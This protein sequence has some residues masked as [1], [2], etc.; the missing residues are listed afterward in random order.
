M[1]KAIMKFKR[2][3]GVTHK[4]TLP[5]AQYVVGST[6]GFTAKPAADNDATDAK[7][8]IEKLFDDTNVDLVVDPLSATYNLP[9]T[10]SDTSDI[11][12]DADVTKMEYVG[13]FQYI[14]PGKEPKSFPGDNNYISV[15]VYSDIRVKVP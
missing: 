5:I 1:A 2:G 8:V 7:A 13:E 14:S 6:L 4:F 15:I 10:A 9:F 12:F 3:D 11:V